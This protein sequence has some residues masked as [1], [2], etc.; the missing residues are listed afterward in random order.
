MLFAVKKK[1]KRDKEIHSLQESHI[2]KYRK[3]RILLYKVGKFYCL[4]LEDENALE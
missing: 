3:K 4:L 1:P 2:E